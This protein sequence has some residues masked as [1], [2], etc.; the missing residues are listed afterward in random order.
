MEPDNVNL[1]Q[2]IQGLAVMSAIPV[3]L[4]GLWADYFG[5]HFDQLVINDPEVER[6]PELEKVKMASLCALVSQ[7]LLFLG[8]TDLREHYPIISPLIFVVAVLTQIFIQTKAE[9]RVQKNPENQENILGISLRATFYWIVGVTLHILFLGLA[10]GTTGLLIQRFHPSF[11][12]GVLALAIAGVFG[13]VVGIVLNIAL[14][15]FYFKHI[16]P[17]RRLEETSVKVQIEACFSRFGF[18]PPEL[19][20]LE[21]QGLKVTQNILVGLK[22]KAG[23]LHK[24][25]RPSLF[26]SSLVLSALSSN[27]IEALTLNQV[28][29][30]V[31]GHARKR[32]L[33]VLA[34]IS[35]STFIA[36]ISVLVGQG[37]SVAEPLVEILG[38]VISFS[39]FLV[40]FRI[41]YLQT[42][43]HEA[44]SD[45]YTVKKMGVTCEDLSSALRKLDLLAD[46]IP[47][48][49]TLISKTP[50]GFPET[51]QR[52]KSMESATSKDHLDRAA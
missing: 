4:L 38:T 19:W 24:A 14:S 17:L 23:T 51:E 22:G 41:L 46:P 12:V 44:E 37:F 26:L 15:P 31:L 10:V 49:V 33:L 30:L 45:V 27:E 2:A 3:V 40:S 1:E 9:N 7:I 5:R 8:S 36:L 42:Q 11:F 13:L 50:V 48:D 35:M 28:S 32:G 29:H 18:E 16:F 43:R 21:L 39:A 25:L 20:V 52:I 47:F 6:E 34:L